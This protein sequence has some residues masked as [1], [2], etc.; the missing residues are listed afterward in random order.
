[1]PTPSPTTT[2]TATPTPTP[3]PT[4]TPTPTPSPTPAA[5]PT[6]TPTPAPAATPTP[7]PTP[8][9]TATPTP[10]PPPTSIVDQIRASCPTNQERAEIDRDFN[11]TFDPDIFMPY[12][13][14]TT[15][16]PPKT[17]IPDPAGVVDLVPNAQLTVYQAFRVMKAMEFDEPLPWTEES[18]YDWLQNAVAGIHFASTGGS[19]C[20]KEGRVIVIGVGQLTD[21]LR[22]TWDGIH[23]IVRVMAHEARH[24]EGL[25]HTCGS[26]DETIGELGAWA[27]HHYV[28]LWVAEHSAPGL[29]SRYEKDKAALDAYFTFNGNICRNDLEFVDDQN[30]WVSGGWAT[31]LK[32]DDGGGTWSS[33][34]SGIRSQVKALSYADDLNGWAVDS[35]GILHTADGGITWSPQGPLGPVHESTSATSRDL[36]GLVFLD[37]KTGFAFSYRFLLHTTDGGIMWTYQQLPFG[38]SACGVFFATNTVIFTDTQYGWI[39]GRRGAVAYTMDGG[40][41]WACQLVWKKGSELEIPWIQD[42][43]FVDRANGWVV[44]G[45]GT[46]FH[47]PDGGV[48]WNP[49]E[50]GVTGRLFGVDFVD[51]QR[52]WA[53]GENGTILHTRDGGVMWT[54][55]DSGVA[56]FLWDV[57]FVSEQEGWVVGDGGLILHTE[58]GGSSWVVQREP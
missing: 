27:V 39:S 51:T 50:S 49:Q 23:G 54:I 7:T 26:N 37:D 16:E 56:S 42:M 13:C 22:R 53:V 29:Y 10:T 6:P 12:E 15:D 9:P 3:T 35:E 8:T 47:T 5:T 18:L 38:K 57:A 31:I 32:T 2:H 14:K 30:G 58:D 36:L 55:Q 28:D 40:S 11:I 21:P 44:G 17:E 34:T 43:A 24:A 41:T 4:A 19:Y 1:M 33:Q 46:I 20:C 25:P 45:R 48:T 52:G